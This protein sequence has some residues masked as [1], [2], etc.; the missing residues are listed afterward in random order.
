MAY[1]VL[2]TLTWESLFGESETLEIQDRDLGSDSNTT[3][4]LQG[5]PI[6]IV[7]DT[8]NDFVFH[9]VNGSRAEL[10]LVT[11][12]NFQFEE[13]YTSDAVKYKVIFK[14]GS[15]I[16][17][18]GFLMPRYQGKYTVAPYPITFVASDRLGTLKNYDWDKLVYATELEM[19]GYI[20]EKTGMGLSMQEGL[21]IYETNHNQTSADSPLDQTYFDGKVFEGKTYYDAL[22]HI[23]FKYL[24]VLRQQDGEWF[25]HRPRE[26]GYLYNLRKWTISGNI[27]TYDS[28]QSYNPMTITTAANVDFDDLVRI[29]DGVGFHTRPGWKN[30]VL[31]HNL[32]AKDEAFN[33]NP[34]FDEW[35]G[36]TPD[37]WDIGGSITYRRH[38]SK[39]KIY[40]NTV[41]SSSNFIRSYTAFSGDTTATQG[42]RINLTIDVGVPGNTDITM[43]FLV[44]LNV[45]TFYRINTDTWVTPTP[46]TIQR[47]ITNSESEFLLQTETI[48]IVTAH[49]PLSPVNSFTLY[50]LAP[51]CSDTDAYIN[52]D[53]AK[54]SLKQYAGERLE[55][56]ATEEDYSDTVDVDN[57]YKPP[58]M[59][60]LLGSSPT[61]A[62]SNVKNIWNGIV[63]VDASANNASYTWNADGRS[64]TLGFLMTAV[65]DDFFQDSQQVVSGPIYTKLLKPCDIIVETNDNN[66]AYMIKRATW[67]PKLNRWDVEMF[68]LPFEIDL[69][70]SG[71][72]E[73]PGKEFL[74]LESESESGALLL[75]SES[76][77]IE[78]E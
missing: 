45:N 27:L 16:M 40:A 26:S 38:P 24:A 65:F 75:E 28:V 44:R 46:Y 23:L 2:Y 68:E 11:Q 4:I 64:G 41:Y 71:A 29:G 60:V 54:C 8:P 53:E 15:D 73:S 20:F 42:I 10:R 37:D 21:N 52:V 6:S 18:Q 72:P 67:H 19:L 58:D 36:S 51:I 59:E 66:R 17:W 30:Y 76:G 69:G 48:E 31:K 25:I 74:L 35:T 47:K 77:G 78:K 70:S 56:F 22:Y 49:L 7:Y 63:F 32:G 55:S 39:L 62:L 14:I 50:I 34:S 43:H 1:G 3:F 13:L 12:S 57:F 61:L 33:A 9:S 5:N